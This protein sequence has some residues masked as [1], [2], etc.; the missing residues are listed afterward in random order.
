MSPNK[1]LV[2][3]DLDGTLFDR[4]MRVE[5][6]KYILRKRLMPLWLL[7]FLLVYIF[8]LKLRPG[9]NPKKVLEFGYSFI[10]GRRVSDMR[11]YADD[12]FERYIKNNLF[13]E[14][15]SILRDHQR[16]GRE[17]VLV[18]NN[19]DLAAKA[20]ADYLSIPFVSTKLEVEGDFYT[21]RIEGEVMY[22]VNKRKWLEA[23]KEGKH[24]ERVWVYT[25]GIS[26]LSLLEAA[27]QPVCVNPDPE[28]AREADKRGW[29]ILFL[30]P[31]A[32][33]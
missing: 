25:D 1:E 3:F 19:D 32:G 24:Y 15:V 6:L 18:T 27:D 20:V 33:I 16:A 30:G 10:K 7:L 23:R 29:P 14:P 2:V 13:K 8:F 22:G 5:F 9:H 28:L 4:R 26:D 17:V 11:A 21:G 12:F 31:T